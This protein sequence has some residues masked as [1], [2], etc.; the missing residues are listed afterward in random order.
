MRS[1][2]ADRHFGGFSRAIAQGGGHV[3]RVSG[4]RP[5][6]E[7]VGNYAQIQATGLAR[8][9]LD[10]SAPVRVRIAPAR[11]LTGWTRDG[12]DCPGG[13]D[14]GRVAV[15]KWRV[16]SDLQEVPLGRSARARRVRSRTAA[17]QAG[18]AREAGGRRRRGDGPG[19]LEVRQSPG[20]QEVK[21]SPGRQEVKQSPGRQE[22][23][24]SPG[25]QEVKQSPG[26]Q[27]VKLSPA[28]RRVPSTR[29]ASNGLWET[30][31]P[32]RARTAR[33]RS[34]R[35]AI[36]MPAEVHVG[37]PERDSRRPGLTAVRV[38]GLGEV[39]RAQSPRAAHPCE[40]LGPGRA[41]QPH[42]FARHGPASMYT[43][44]GRSQR[45]CQRV[46]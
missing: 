2:V 38:H 3:G 23:R 35:R 28:G 34:P 8:P 40:T 42:P 13:L 4:W 19:W 15:G 17:G 18:A 25:R 6:P 16:F 41:R 39:D 12:W 44:N 43:L 21:Q 37:E 45:V 20:R 46:P 24:Q 26:R 29:P 31:R 10:V 33:G 32:T 9:V 1:G 36:R 14:F 5:P 30:P 22:V 7:P 11:C 27:E